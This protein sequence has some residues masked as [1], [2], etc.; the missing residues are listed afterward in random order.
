VVLIQCMSDPRQLLAKYNEA[1]A[2]QNA[3]GKDKLQM[4]SAELRSVGAHVVG[5]K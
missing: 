3:T 2:E 1:A 5:A 4:W